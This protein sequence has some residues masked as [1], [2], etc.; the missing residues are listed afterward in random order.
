M[1][2]EGTQVDMLVIH[3]KKQ[4]RWLSF[5]RASGESSW[6]VFHHGRISRYL[7]WV[8]YVPTMN[9]MDGLVHYHQIWTPRK[10]GSLEATQMGIIWYIINIYSTYIKID[11][12]CGRRP[13]IY[14]YIHILYTH[15]H[16][17]ISQ[18]AIIRQPEHLFCSFDFLWLYL[19][20]W[21]PMNQQSWRP[22]VD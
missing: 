18:I 10:Y 9:N 7:S 15:W 14:I 2:F 22:L 19:K 8:E 20:A 5:G 3:P 4:V 1:R 12:S 13:C 6:N 11:R 16:D 17:S 21:H